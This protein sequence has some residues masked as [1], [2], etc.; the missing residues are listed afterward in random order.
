MGKQ[1]FQSNPRV[2]Q[3]FDELD[4]YRDFCVEFG[5]VFNEAHLGNDH[6]PYAD[7]LRYQQGKLPRDNWG[8]AI[9]QGHK[10]YVE[11]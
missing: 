11:N 6:S 1:T 2:H 3:I 9:K 4:R 8:W 5:F 7:F 10:N